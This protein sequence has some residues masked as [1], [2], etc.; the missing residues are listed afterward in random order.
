MAEPTATDQPTDAAWQALTVD[1]ALAQQGVDQARGLSSAEVTERRGRFGPNRFAEQKTEPRWQAFLRQYADPMQVVLVVAGLLSIYPVGQASTGVMLILLT[2]L[3]AYMGL[4]QEGKAAAAVAALQQM[5]VVKARVIRDRQ[6]T[7]IPA[8]EL[9]PG[10]IVAFEAGDVVTADGRVIAAATLEI[11]EAALTGESLPVAKEIGPVAADAPLGDRHDMAYMNTNVTRGSGRMVVTATGMATEVG[12]ISGM[13]QVDTGQDTPLTRQI[14][15]LSRQ[16]LVIAGLALLASMAIGRLRYDQPF[17]VLFV[18]AIAFA[19][20]A[21]P[22]G[23]PAVITTILSYGTQTLAKAGAI[24]KQLRSV[25]TLGSTSAINS[26]KTGTLTLNQMTAVEM[27]IPGRR[28]TISGTGY[29]I[30][31]TIQRTG[32]DSDVPLDA[33]LLPCVLASDAVVKE[34]ELIGDPT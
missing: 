7:E 4:N 26:D 22:T 28:Y 19:V 1:E 6:L 25:E 32:G 23:L 15:Q 11:D 33:F 27:T 5:M 30:D 29:G 34:G 17:D 10:D 9:V 31:G 18:T 24:V 21:I 13:L 12:H 14:N 3:N 2:L 8:E 20:S 16:L